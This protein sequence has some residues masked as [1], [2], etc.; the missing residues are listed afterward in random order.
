MDLV[1]CGCS[2]FK[3]T[4]KYKKAIL[5]LY[6]WVCD[7][8]ESG[9][10]EYQELQG[11]VARLGISDE[12]E[13]RM[14]VPF[15]VKADVIAADHAIRGGSKIRSLIIDDDFFTFHG[16]CFIQFLKIETI[17]EE[18]EDD[19]ISKV[20][21]RI[22]HKL[23]YFQYASL[24]E[25]DEM[26]YKDIYDFVL[27]YG[28]MDKT[29]FFIMTTLR[30]MNEWE[31]LDETVKKY[32]NDEIGEIKIVKN[33]NDYQYIT[34]LLNQYGVLQVKD[35]QQHLAAYYKKILEVTNERV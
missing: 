2:G 23:S 4:L 13:I 31:S 33:V 1:G 7:S 21:N 10:I 30:K 5:S 15:L 28:T 29:E 16:Q 3:Y 26:V 24:M 6:D 18:F 8:S 19:E 27:K 22:Y 17:R 11:K 14:I 34:G 25:S 12:S 35:K 32:R 9:E 20:I